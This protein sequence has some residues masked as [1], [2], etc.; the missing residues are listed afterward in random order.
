[1][2]NFWECGVDSCKMHCVSGTSYCSAHLGRFKKFGTPTPLKTCNGCGVEFVWVALAF[3]KKAHCD[4][5]IQILKLYEDHIPL[6]TTSITNHGITVVEYL[7]IL[8]AQGFKCATCNTE[9]NV[10]RRLSIDHDHSCCEGRYGCRD[11]IRGLLCVP[12]NNTVG[13]IEFYPEILKNLERHQKSRP[14]RG[15]YG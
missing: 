6:I 10:K 4:I 8:E 15:N 7:K 2:D 1:M 5:C 3:R 12:C 11:C 9:S 14:L 13:L